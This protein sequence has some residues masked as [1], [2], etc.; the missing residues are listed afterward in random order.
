MDNQVNLSGFSPN[1]H[2]EILL[3]L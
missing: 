1:Y 2:L 3:T